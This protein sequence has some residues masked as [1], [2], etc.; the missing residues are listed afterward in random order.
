MALYT[1]NLYG[2]ILVTDEA[3]RTVVGATALESY[4]VNGL[5]GWTYNVEK[6]KP[7]KGDFKRAVR[8]DTRDNR[9]FI[10]LNVILKYGMSVDAVTVSLR[11]AIKYNVELFTGMPVE[12]ININVLGIK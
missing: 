2:K 3:V 8:V 6:G 4:G 7:S 11:G 10:E 1:S 5:Y 12:V 9:I